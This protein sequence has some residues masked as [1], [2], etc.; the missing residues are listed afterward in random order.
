MEKILAL[1]PAVVTTVCHNFFSDWHLPSFYQSVGDAEIIH[2][3]L[4][5]LHTKL[6]YE[7]TK[8]F[9]AKVDSLAHELFDSVYRSF[10]ADG[11]PRRRMVRWTGAITSGGAAEPWEHLLGCLLIEI[12]AEQSGLGKSIAHPQGAGRR[13]ARQTEAASTQNLITVFIASLNGGEPITVSDW[14]WLKSLFETG[15]CCV[16]LMPPRPA[17]SAGR[18][19][20]AA[21][22]ARGVVQAKRAG[23]I[24]SKHGGL[25]AAIREAAIDGIMRRRRVQAAWADRPWEGIEIVS[26]D[27]EIAVEIDRIY[28]TYRSIMHR[29]DKT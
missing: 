2:A 9:H 6:A 26:D 12:G 17:K 28:S 15:L 20:M 29:T 7:A 1:H 27:P 8:D 23:L 14:S 25:A 16:G 11:M 13:K 3:P 10:C 21:S 4:A 24:A 18:P 19:P 22:Q 5:G